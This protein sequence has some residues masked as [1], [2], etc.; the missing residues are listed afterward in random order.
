MM[1]NF[2]IAPFLGLMTGIFIT[3]GRLI[4]IA[5]FAYLLLDVTY[6]IIYYSTQ[7]FYFDLSHFEMHKL[8]LAI[9]ASIFEGLCDMVGFTLLAFLG[10][11][12][13]AKYIEKHI[14]KIDNSIQ[15]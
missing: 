6:E 7:P 15:H 14:K 10:G 12:V 11:V 3:K 13:R 8:P 1:I 4:L 5:F 9:G 2:L